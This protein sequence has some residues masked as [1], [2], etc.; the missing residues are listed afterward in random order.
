MSRF[1]GHPACVAIFGYDRGIVAIEP[2]IQ[3]RIASY[4]SSG[5]AGYLADRRNTNVAIF[6]GQVFHGVIRGS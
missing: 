1:G 5:A 4:S 2:I 3:D 6:E